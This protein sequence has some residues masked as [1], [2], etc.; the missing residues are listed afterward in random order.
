MPQAEQDH[1]DGLIRRSYSLGFDVKSIDRDSR[2]IDYVFSDDTIDSYDEIVDQD[3]DLSRY[4]KNPVILYDHN[5]AT[6]WGGIDP[7]HSLPIGRAENV[8][9][10]NN[11]LRGRVFLASSDANPLAEQCWKLILE[12]ILRAG[13]VGFVP[14]DVIEEK[15]DGKEIYRL[16]KNKLFEYSL[17]PIG[18]NENAL[19]NSAHSERDRAL[20]KSWAQRAII[21]SSSPLGENGT[22]GMDPKELEAEVARLKSANAA[23][24]IKASESAGEAK[25]NLAAKESLEA[26]CSTLETQNKTLEDENASLKGQLIA[27][28]VTPLVGKKIAPAQLEKFVKLRLEWGKEDF[29][30]FVKNMADLPHTKTITEDNGATNKNTATGNKSTGASKVLAAALKA[31]EKASGEDSTVEA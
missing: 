9:V 15:R 12:N 1:D 28:E 27:S 21:I 5:K 14:G 29:D 23:L 3:W 10:E 6:R 7:K 30:D 31:A 11:T 2:S 17:T 16:R 8:R 20:L 13:S 22:T 19:A 4:L 24:E 25:K 26:K 18:A